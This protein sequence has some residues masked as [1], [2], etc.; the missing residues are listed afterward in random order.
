MIPKIPLKPNETLL[1][2]SSNYALIIRKDKYCLTL[3]CYCLDS[4]NIWCE[5]KLAGRE[6]FQL[7]PDECFELHDY[8]TNYLKDI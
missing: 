3:D 6:S 7:F 2:Q 1:Y 4:Y 5:G 8:L